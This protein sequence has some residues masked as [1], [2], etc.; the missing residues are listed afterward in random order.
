[1]MLPRFALCLLLFGCTVSLAQDAPSETQD[2]PS[3][4]QDA[5]SETQDAP[6]EPDFVGPTKDVTCHVLWLIESDDE[7]RIAYSGPARGGLTDAGYGRLVPAGSA[8]AVVSVG[9]C[10]T[11]TGSSRYGDMSVAASLLNTTEQG[12]LQVKIKLQTGNRSPLMIETTARAPLGR[13]FLVGGADS[14]VGLPK[15]ANDGK[16]A[17]AIMRIGEGVLLLD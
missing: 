5:S 12:E 15:H 4:T 6:S 2:A 14:R 8:A 11:V 17:V 16:R 13:W 7:N 10:S 3:E 9:Q 1:M